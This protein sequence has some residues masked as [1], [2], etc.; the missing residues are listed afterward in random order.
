MIIQI[1]SFPILT[2]QNAKRCY[3]ISLQSTPRTAPVQNKQRTNR[4]ND[5][6]NMGGTRL[7]KSLQIRLV[8]FPTDRQTDTFGRTTS[9]FSKFQNKMIPNDNGCLLTHSIENEY[10]TIDYINWLTDWLASWLADWLA[11]Y[12]YVANVRTN[13]K[14]K[15]IIIIKYQITIVALA[16]AAA[17]EIDPPTSSPRFVTHAI[18][19]W[20][21]SH[22]SSRNARVSWPGNRNRPQ[23]GQ[24]I[25]CSLAKYH[26]WGY[27]LWDL[28]Q[29]CWHTE[30]RGFRVWSR[31]RWFQSISKA[32]WFHHPNVGFYLK[33]YKIEKKSMTYRK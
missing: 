13:A 10:P 18:Q 32:K 4:Q 30:Y 31:P 15:Q 20:G 6:Q 9:G 33:L 11:G 24:T 21:F 8:G 23:L 16:L 26:I 28:G 17:V 1:P 19:H 12:S 29:M 14:K 5:E 22:F 27:T 2:K 3:I 7:N 25:K